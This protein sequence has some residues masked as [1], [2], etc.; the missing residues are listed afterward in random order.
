MDA[1]LDSVMLSTVDDEDRFRTIIDEL[2]NQK[3]VEKFKVRNII[4]FELKS[5]RV[6]FLFFRCKLISN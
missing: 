2:I 1:I 3:L 6:E 4:V 5:Y